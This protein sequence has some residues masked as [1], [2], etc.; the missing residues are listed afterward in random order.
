M[1]Y[2]EFY[3]AVSVENIATCLS[4]MPDRVILIGDGAQIA[5]RKA[6]YEQLFRER[7]YTDVEILIKSIPKTNLKMAAEKIRQLVDTYGDC[8][9]DITGGEEL[10]VL[11][12][13]MV[14]ATAPEGKIQ[15]HKFN[16]AEGKMY[17]CDF[18]G[19][20]VFR[21]IPMLSVQEN[22]RIYGG[23]VVFGEAG[24]M[25]TKDTCRWEFTEDFV[26]DVD[27]LWRICCQ[28]EHYWNLKCIIF[29]AICEADGT[30]NLTVSAAIEDLK[31]YLPSNVYYN[32][33]DKLIPYLCSTGLLTYFHDNG[34]MV[35]L[36]FK[37][38]QVK[39]CLLIEGQVLEL[40]MFLLARGLTDGQ[41]PMYNDALC[42]VKI[43]WDG[44]IHDEENK[45][46]ENE[47]DILLMHGVVPI[48]ISCKNGIKVE[49]DELYKL[50]T[51]AHRFGG[52]YAKMVLIAP[53]LGDN[54]FTTN[55]CERAL[56]MGIH[57]I[58]GAALRGADDA[59]LG[60]ALSKL[61]K[62]TNGHTVF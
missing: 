46:V 34:T 21:D 8:V 53:T 30:G 55:L 32:F 59:A 28:E 41:A 54:E 18:D 62:K 15:I 7:G 9:F 23:D 6:G 51:V 16:L 19:E 39:R 24:D 11:A 60:E 40:K 43:D 61:W 26:A 47:I 56:E 1:T 58:G 33:G 3:D 22:I 49:V 13:G 37:N 2:V 57:V 52:P 45:D 44:V 17:D 42:G 29:E 35:T 36:T 27:A 4:C 38:E 20:T 12:L 31:R 48:F 50:Q 14:C 10:L 5:Q 25:T